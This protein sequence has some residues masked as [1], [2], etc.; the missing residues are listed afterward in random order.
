VDDTG[1]THFS[2]VDSAGNCVAVTETINTRFGSMVFVEELGLVLNNE[3]DDFA[4]EPGKP[5]AYGLVQSERSA[6]RPRSRPL[7]SM[8]PTIVLREGQPYLVL[9]ASGGPRIITG[10]LQAVLR[11]IDFGASPAEAIGDRRV[12]HQWL[13]DHVEF[14]GP[15][16]DD[17]KDDLR[18]RGHTVS[19]EPGDEAAVQMI[20][21]E[22]NKMI[23]VSDP[24]KHG[25]PAGVN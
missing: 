18:S 6:V 4:A 9:G 22:P 25:R 14:D 8:S 21:I 23:G 7:S 5:N 19:D 24:R 12:H 20:V 13:P 1:T 15:V 17:I 3:M 16:A 2:V 11:M 10:V